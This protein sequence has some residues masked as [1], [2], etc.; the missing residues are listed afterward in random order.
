MRLS[1]PLMA[2]GLSI[3][4]SGC[5]ALVSKFY[6]PVQHDPDV[7]AQIEK[8]VSFDKIVVTRIPIEDVA[9]MP[10]ILNQRFSDYRALGSS[11]FWVA[12]GVTD[13]DFRL[14]AETVGASVVVVFHKSKGSQQTG[15]V[16]TSVPLG[17]GNSMAMAMPTY[18]EVTEY[19]GI[20][21]AKYLG[22]KERIGVSVEGLNSEIQQKFE[23]NKGVVVKSLA[24]GPAFDA[25]VLLG[26]L[27][28][29]IN[30]QEVIDDRSALTLIRNACR[31][32]TPFSLVV[33]RGTNVN[34]REILIKECI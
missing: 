3:V 10:E 12:S 2:V 19:H 26:D 7:L 11:D 5:V 8:P 33:L 21:L 30:G 27:I 32:Q 17:G 24:R 15:A 34:R 9:A 28:V 23:R 29:S 14:Q 13:Y 18:A 4:L 20:Y 22:G 16:A 25:N 6:R 31:Q 1:V